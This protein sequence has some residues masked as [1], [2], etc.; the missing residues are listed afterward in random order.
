MESLSGLECFIRS[1][2]LGSFAA[3]ARQLGLTPAAVSKNVARLEAGLGVRLF[4]RSTRSLHLTEAGAGFLQDVA[5]SLGTLRGAIANLA[6]AHGQPGGVL[7][8]SMGAVF[9]RDYVLPLLGEFLERYPAIR[10]D[11]HFDNRP[12]DLIAEGYDAAIG[13]GFDLTPG[14]V[15]RKLVNAHLVLLAAPAYL[16]RHGTPACPADLAQHDGIRIRSPQTG[17]VRAWPLTQRDG[18]Q[19]PI[20]LRER[21]YLSDPE[22]ACVAACAGLGITLVSTMHAQPY[23]DDGRLQRVLPSWYVDAG[24]T[25]VYYAAH[26]LLPAKTRVFVDFLLER[27]AAQGLLARSSAR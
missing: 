10:P 18:G 8:V 19:A 17:R 7:K 24:D 14:V 3:A 22:A 5:P 2:Q 6:S 4:Q 9:G 1:A 12:V 11:W 20:T 27:F 13:G 16:A 26:R 25:S 23:L 21:I 15:A